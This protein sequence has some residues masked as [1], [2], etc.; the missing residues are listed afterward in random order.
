MLAR[1]FTFPN[2]VNEVAARTT[3]AGVVVMAI[4]LLLLQQPIILW[5]LA[6][7]F[8]ARAAA[9]PKISPLALLST[10]VIAPRLAAEPRPTPGP[11]KRF[12]Q[13]LGA[14]MTLLGV[15]LTFGF[16]L[17]GAAYVVAAVLVVL[18][19]LESAL[20]ICVGCKIFSVLM[21]AHVIPE[22]VCEE[23]NNIWLR[24]RGVAAE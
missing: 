3:A 19:G 16:G 2:P 22:T 21:A 24:P 14:V 10:R 15:V 9:G 8:V 6:Y 23:C 1:F 4:L 17:T 11:P 7:G 18:A 20:N 12:A 13:T 5:V